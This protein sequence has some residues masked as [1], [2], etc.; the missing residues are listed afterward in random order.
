MSSPAVP[1]FNCSP[2]VCGIREDEARIEFRGGTFCCKDC[3]LEYHA[4][5]AIDLLRTMR[6]AE[7]SLFNV[8]E[9]VRTGR[10]TASEICRNLKRVEDLLDV[11][12]LSE[13]V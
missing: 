1:C 10:I 5:A 11:K 4:P 2:N 9:D 6:W 7:E 8:R 12:G 13:Y 3:L